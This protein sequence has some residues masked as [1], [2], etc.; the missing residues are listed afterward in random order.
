MPAGGIHA[1]LREMFKNHISGVFRSV[2]FTYP[3]KGENAI[4]LH[5][6]LSLRLICKPI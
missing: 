3:L 2:A 6:D 5:S 1:F 4:N